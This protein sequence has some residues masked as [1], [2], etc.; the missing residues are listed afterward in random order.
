MADEVNYRT[1]GAVTRVGPDWPLFRR[2]SWG[3]I[4]A[5]TVVALGTGLLLT[6]FG[7]F[8]GFAMY[9]PQTEAQPA[10]GIPM[11]TMI[12]YLITAFCSLFAGG[13]VAARLAGTPEKGTGML[14][15]LVTWGLTTISSVLFGILAIGGLLRVSAQLMHTLVAGISPALANTMATQANQMQ[16][17][18]ADAAAQLQQQAPQ[19]AG[20]VADQIWGLMLLLF[21]GTLLGAVAAL[22]GGAAGRLKA[23]IAPPP[24]QVT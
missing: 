14:H 15:G 17:Q 8:V 22:L 9:N 24:P 12:W 20:V 21:V 16:K 3:A 1:E 18:A 2:I 5:G 11:W 4:F 6:L 13:W 19:I 23:R 10:A 7:F